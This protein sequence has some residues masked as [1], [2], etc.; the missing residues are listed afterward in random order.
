MLKKTELKI[1]L[2]ELELLESFKV[3]DR[4]IQDK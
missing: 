1:Q 2:N 4:K 3:K